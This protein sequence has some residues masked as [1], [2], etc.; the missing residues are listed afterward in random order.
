MS[1]IDHV[2]FYE[3]PFLKF[4]RLL[5]TYLTTIPRGFRSFKTAMPI[6][7]KQKLFQK[8]IL[9][10]KLGKLAGSKEWTGSLLFTEHHM[11]HAASSYFPSPFSTAAV[12]T[13]D[14]VGEWCTTSIGHGIDDR[15]SI[16]K[17]IHFPHSLGLLYSAFTYYTGFKVNSGEYKLMG[18][19]P[20]GRP[21]FAQTILDYLIDLKEDG[22]FRLDQQYFD[23]CTG[24]TMT[25]RAFHRLFGAEPRK[26][27]SAL[28][29]REMDLAA[30]VQAVT[31]EVV[32]KLARFAQLETGERNLCLAGG[33][34]LNASQTVSS[35]RQ[36]Y[37]RTSGSSRQPATPEVL[38]AR[39]LL[40]G[41]ASS[42]MVARSMVAIA[43]RVLIL[44]PPTAK[45]RS[46]SALLPPEPSTTFFQTPRL[47]RAPSML[48]L[49]RRL[50]DG[51]K[52]AWNSGPAHSGPDPYWAIRGRLP[53]R[54][55]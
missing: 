49:R 14:G 23:Y 46:N 35:L 52:G 53:C 47:P 54:E 16:F 45:R 40:F 34:A 30:S 20:Y 19:A 18:L 22:S 21:R 33:V 31:E 41:T 6:W 38:L 43:W 24:L 29:Q 48:S 4:E 7:I 55:R 32:L 10:Q 13:M 17:E 42:A 27:E 9:R 3:K 12:L 26:P 39:P 51:C 37:S 11:A 28:T 2:V 36:A 15:L 8:K 5:E 44:A 1:E 25:S 50:W